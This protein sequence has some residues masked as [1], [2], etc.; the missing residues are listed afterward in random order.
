M[1]QRTALTLFHLAAALLL[2]GCTLRPDAPLPDPDL[3]RTLRGGTAL[4]AAGRDFGERAWWRRFDDPVLDAL[5]DEA[6]AA[7]HQ[8]HTA[9]ATVQQAEA[10]LRAA[11]LAWLPTLA[12]TGGGVAAGG[13]GTSLSSRAGGTPGGTAVLAAPGTLTAAYGGFMPAYAVNIFS[14]INQIRLAEATLEVHRAAHHAVRLTVIGG[15]AGGYFDL[16]A[17]RRQWSLQSRLIA[18]L[19]ALHALESTRF[20]DGGNSALPAEQ[21]ASRLAAARAALPGIEDGIARTE[22]ALRLLAGQNPGAVETKASPLDFPTAGQVPPN[23]PASVLLHRPDILMAGHELKQ[24]EAQVGLAHSAFFPEIS[25][26]GLGGGASAMLTNL[27]SASTGLWA[28]SAAVSVPLINPRKLA[29]VSAADKGY[30]SARSNYLQTVKAALAEVDDRLTG[31]GQADARLIQR[32]GA[33]DAARRAD[34]IVQARHQAGAVDRRAL[35][36]AQLDL[37]DADI[38]LNTAKQQQLAD[39]VALYQSL[40]GGYAVTPGPVTGRGRRTSG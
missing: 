11:R 3:P 25:L 20:R 9:I 29:D 34:R 40:A 15:V 38:A 7:N 35:L 5:I 26:T 22:N 17:A 37:D 18:H 32:Q 33:L 28:A 27:L 13:L 14:N 23:L 36:Q 12:T 19:E 24:A 39:L 16:L 4:I 21:L 30:Q 31:L 6:L 1:T 10:Q 8:I 2:A